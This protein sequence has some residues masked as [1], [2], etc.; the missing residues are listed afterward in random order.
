MGRSGHARTLTLTTVATVLA[1]LPVWLLAG[2]APWIKADLGFGRIGLGAAIGLH[3][4]IAALASIPSGWLVERIGWPLALRL[5]AALSA[6]SMFGIGVLAE[7]WSALMAFL[8]VSALGFSVTHPAANLCLA[9]L[10]PVSRQGAAFGLKQASLPLTTLAVGL[11]VPWFA[12]QGGWRWATGALAGCAGVF[13]AVM[14]RNRHR[15]HQR[16]AS[17]PRLSPDDPGEVASPGRQSSNTSLVILATGA[18]VGSAATV[19]LGGFLVLYGVHAGLPPSGAGLLL[20]I[21]SLVSFFSRLL[22]GYLADR[23]GRR[24]LLIVALMMLGGA[25]AFLALAA[26]GPPWTIV[27]A[28]AGAFGLGWSWN[29]L[30]AFAIVLNNSDRPA[31]ATGV[32]QAAIAAGGAGGALLFG[33]ASTW[34]SFAVA[35]T[36][37]ALALTLAASLVTWGRSTLRRR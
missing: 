32:V 22:T 13:L 16:D 6:L 20:G 14:V 28:A 12:H 23:R 25:A 7:S 33:L 35:W 30:F 34:L 18:G 37:A 29:G 3:F 26:G 19:S 5:A 21:G 15:G 2:F 17:R 10:I 1:N 31:T 8:A 11:L 4:A 24:H 27:L 9:Q 36:G